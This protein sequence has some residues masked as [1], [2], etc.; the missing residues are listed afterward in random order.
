MCSSDLASVDLAQI[1]WLPVD[2]VS[3]SLWL[4]VRGRNL[5]NASVRD[6]RYFPRPGRNFAVAVE[7]VF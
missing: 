3:K 7:G 5:A 6:G 1:A 2:R 4:S